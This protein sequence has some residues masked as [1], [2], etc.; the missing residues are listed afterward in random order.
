[1]DYTTAQGGDVTF[2]E[3]GSLLAE[4]R[5][6]VLAARPLEASDIELQNEGSKT[7]NVSAEV[8]ADR[9]TTAKTIYDTALTD[10]AERLHR[11][12]RSARSTSKT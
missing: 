7:Q 9:I 3:L 11:R 5:T 10:L 6:L 1:M 2:F 4:L 12:L 8:R